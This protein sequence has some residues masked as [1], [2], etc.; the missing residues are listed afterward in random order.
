MVGLFQI[1]VEV[2]PNWRREDLL[3]NRRNVLFKEMLEP[4][5]VVASMAKAEEKATNGL[6]ATRAAGSQANNSIKEAFQEAFK[7]TR[8]VTGVGRQVEVKVH[9]FLIE[10]ELNSIT[11][12]Q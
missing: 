10:V 3:L 2:G 8:R 5:R 11:R 6:N 12:V 7:Y 9:R 1:R 4:L